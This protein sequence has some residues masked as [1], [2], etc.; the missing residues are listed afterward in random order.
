MSDTIL[1]ARDLTRHYQVSRG[2]LKG[3]A[4]VKALNGVS[5]DLMPGRTLAVVGESGCGKSTLA[6]QRT[7][8][9]APTSGRLMLDGVD[10]S[11]SGA[12]VV[13][14][15]RQKVKMV[16]QNSYGSLNSR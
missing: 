10:V 5:F 6:R 7:L 14:K 13:K 4:T 8:I 15:L 16:S 11:Q 2:F 12:A 9:E 1:S 3:E